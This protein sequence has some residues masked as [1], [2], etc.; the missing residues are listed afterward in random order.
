MVKDGDNRNKQMKHAIPPIKAEIDYL[1][2]NEREIYCVGDWVQTRIEGKPTPVRFVSIRHDGATVS[3]SP[4]FEGSI[5]SAEKIL[6]NLY[7]LL[8]TSKG[9]FST[10]PALCVQYAALLIEVDNAI[11][12]LNIDKNI[13]KSATIKKWNVDYR[14]W[15]EKIR[16]A[17]KCWGYKDYRETDDVCYFNPGFDY[18]QFLDEHESYW[19]AL[20]DK[21]SALVKILKEMGSALEGKI[22]DKNQSLNTSDSQLKDDNNDSAIYVSYSWTMMDEVDN[23]CNAFDGAKLLYKRDV[24]DCT[25]RHNI[26][27][28]EEEIGRGA[29][30]LALIND[31][32]LKSINCMYELARVFQCGN[33]ERRLY[34]IVSIT[35]H[36]GSEMLTELYEHWENIYQEKKTKLNDL[37]SGISMQVIDELAYCGLIIGEIPKIVSYLTQTNTLTF[38]DL[39]S[40]DYEMLIN[41]LRK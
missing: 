26:H 17:E 30:V 27:Q 5:L 28:F 18:K 31:E 21:I 40:N 22:V 20:Q 6:S 4:F 14:S 35:G 9:L 25:Y 19:Q 34:P 12:R 41:E 36:R 3:N 11:V 2:K 29:R 1:D 37:P 8:T 39:S 13:L 24:K 16:E 33:V 15:A 7:S 10:R 32:Y 38:N 23:M